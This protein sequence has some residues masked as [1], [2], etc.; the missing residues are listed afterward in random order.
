[1]PATGIPE[2]ALPPAANPHRKEALTDAI[3]NLLRVLGAGLVISLLIL[4][5]L[6]AI[7]VMIRESAS[8]VGPFPS[9]RTKPGY[10]F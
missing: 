10:W 6:P 9:S 2:I 4:R 8:P 1:M 5:E 7:D 3:A